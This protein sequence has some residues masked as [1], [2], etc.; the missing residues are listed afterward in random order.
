MQILMTQPSLT[1]EILDSKLQQILKEISVFK[2]ESMFVMTH[3]TVNQEFSEL[4]SIPVLKIIRPR[5]YESIGLA[6]LMK[7]R[8]GFI[9]L[10]TVSK[11]LFRQHKK[12]KVSLRP[13]IRLSSPTVR[14]IS[15]TKTLT[16]GQ[17]FGRKTLTKGQTFGTKTLTKGQT[18]GTMT[19]KR[20][21]KFDRYLYWFDRLSHRSKAKILINNR[22]STLTL[23][24]CLSQT[25]I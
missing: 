15:G 5:Q 9:L 22:H 11:L 16:K 14:Q 19:A 10:T 17:T 13:L 24:S 25:L 4:P 18:F 20:D 6:R 1:Q 2:T 3:H 7:L 21:S 8:K 23:I 12:R